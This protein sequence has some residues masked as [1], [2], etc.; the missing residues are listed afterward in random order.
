MHQLDTGDMMFSLA[1]REEL[2]FP[3]RH[4]TPREQQPMAYPEPDEMLNLSTQW[5]T[6]SEPTVPKMS[7]FDSDLSF[8][9]QNWLDENQHSHLPAH[10]TAKP[11]LS[12]ESIAH[13][14]FSPSIAHTSSPVQTDWDMLLSATSQTMADFPWPTTT[15]QPI[16]VKSE[17]DSDSIWSLNDSPEEPQPPSAAWPYPQK[18]RRRSEPRVTKPSRRPTNR[19]H[20]CTNINTRPDH[21]DLFAP[22]PI[23]PR[24]SSYE[25]TMFNNLSHGSAVAGGSTSAPTVI[26]L[27]GDD[28]SERAAAHSKRI[29]HKISEKSRRNRLTFAIRQIQKL[30]PPQEGDSDE[31][32]PNYT[33]LPVSKVDVVEMSIA[34]IARLKREN[35]EAVGR[36]KELEGL[37]M[38]EKVGKEGEGAEAVVVGDDK[39]SEKV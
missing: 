39:T 37:L 1:T 12:Q 23:T 9:A 19:L 5:L 24:S 31:R 38:K 6:Y 29:A 26:D 11:V 22:I 32:S 4:F 30:L 28:S 25:T 36:V 15:A 27:C 18:F 10:N 16:V 20:P 21:P 8:F 17:D 34:Y 13:D 7:T 3:E 35:E 33:G 2:S 14:L